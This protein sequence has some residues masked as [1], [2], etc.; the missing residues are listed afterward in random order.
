MSKINSGRMRMDWPWGMPV[1]TVTAADAAGWKCWGPFSLFEITELI[2][3]VKK[4]SFTGNVTYDYG[5]GYSEVSEDYSTDVWATPPSAGTNEATCFSNRTVLGFLDFYDSSDAMLLRMAD[6]LVDYDDY[7][8]PSLL[9]NGVIL[10]DENFDF[11]LRPNFF[12]KP[13]GGGNSALFFEHAQGDY[14]AVAGTLVLK[15]GDFNIECYT[16]IQ[17]DY[18]TSSEFT[19]TAVEWFPYATSTG[20]PAWDTATGAPINGGPAA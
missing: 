10:R 6:A 16:T 5:E 9:T 4:L 11:W 7:G 3:R 15:S 18:V 2:Y 8:M 17:T 13:T 1:A 20:Q 19:I 12:Y 14:H